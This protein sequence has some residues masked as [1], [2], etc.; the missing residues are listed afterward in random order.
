[1]K[2]NPD[3]FKLRAELGA[4]KSKLEAV[5]KE[6]SET[7]AILADQ[8]GDLGRTD[9][10]VAALE[11]S[12]Q[13][14]DLE[15]LLRTV[16][17]ETDYEGEHRCPVCSSYGAHSPDCAWLRFAC[18]VGGPALIESLFVQFCNQ[19]AMN[20][21]EDARRAEAEARRSAQAAIEEQR[22]GRWGCRHDRQFHGDALMPCAYRGCSQGFSSPHIRMI[23]KP[24]VAPL[25]FRSSSAPPNPVMTHTTY[26]RREGFN[27][28]RWVAEPALGLVSDVDPPRVPMPSFMGIPVR[29]ESR[30]LLDIVRERSGPTFNA[31]LESLMTQPRAFEGM[32]PKTAT[33]INDERFEQAMA[34]VPS[35]R[36]EVFSDATEL[37]KPPDGENIGK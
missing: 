7:R 31:A 19:Q 23:N 20:E 1:M 16:E 6:L 4:A 37:Q 17:Q 36:L 15:T 25:V 9:D 5:L 12:G 3:L 35:R 14:V 28:S 11:A 34:L 24:E 18:A 27:E 26:T 30:T 8:R 29:P 13:R 10:W 21:R 22:L 2:E 32:Q 33:Q